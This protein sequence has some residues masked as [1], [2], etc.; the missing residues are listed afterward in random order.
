MINY[1]SYNDAWGISPS[2]NNL[3]THKKNKTEERFVNNKFNYEHNMKKKQKTYN[4][5]NNY[6]NF[7][8]LLNCKECI[9][10]LKKKLNENN[11]DNDNNS[12]SKN[13]IE[14]FKNNVETFNDKMKNIILIFCKTKKS[15]DMLLILLIIAFIILSF[16]FVKGRGAETKG[17]DIEALA[18]AVS[19]AGFNMKYLKENFVMIP[20]NIVNFSPNL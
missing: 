2:I 4:K 3:Q 13:M 14:T 7:E 6:I 10:K 16:F 20:K 8:D 5:V 11:N 19:Q 17:K 1:S 9:K 15:K 18:E 12:N